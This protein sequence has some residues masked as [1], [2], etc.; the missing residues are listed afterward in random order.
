[1]EKPIY[2]LLKTG[3]CYGSLWLKTGNAR[4]SFVEV[5]HIEIHEN[6]SKRSGANTRTQTDRRAYIASTQDVL[7]YVSP[8]VCQYNTLRLA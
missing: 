4:H 5:S 3:L 7:L 8:V 6:V 2:G 1:M